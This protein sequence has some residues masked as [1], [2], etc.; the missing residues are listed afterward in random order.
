MMAELQSHKMDSA[1]SRYLAIASCFISFWNCFGAESVTLLLK[2]GDRLTG[3]MVTMDTS[4]VTITNS[5]IGKIAVPVAQ[6]EKMEKQKAE[7]PAQPA[8]TNQTAQPFV[9]PAAPS[10][11]T[12]QPAPTP[13]A[14]QPAPPGPKPAETATVKPDPAKPAAPP[15]AAVQPKPK[16]PKR[17]NATVDVGFDLQ[18]NQRERQLYYGRAKWTYGKDRFRSIVDY[19]TNYG[20]TDGLLT[21]NDMN[22]S[23]K[24]EWDMT[25]KLYVFDAAGAGYND[26]RKIDLSY[27]DSFGL[28]YKVLNKSNFLVKEGSLILNTDLGGNYQQQFLSDGTDRNYFSLRLG[29]IAA[30]KIN[31]KLSFDEK[32]EYYPRF[33]GLDDFRLRFEATLRYTLAPNLTLNLT[34]IDLYDTQPAPGVSENDL[35]LRASVGLRF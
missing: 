13:V 25:K 2:N 18:Y 34:A 19:I 11:A 35:L 21:A 26:I 8:T 1:F 10:T 17:W 31:T 23:V 15:P 24:L 32:L 33:T 9:A 5:L 12:N 4:Y 6:V 28:G 22:G 14:T 16:P 29:E 30:W 27:D 20:E 3:E 7:K